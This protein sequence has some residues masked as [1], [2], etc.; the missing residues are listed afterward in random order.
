MSDYQPGDTITEL[1]RHPNAG[2]ADADFTKKL[3]KNNVASN[4]IV[5]VDEIETN[6]YSAS[7]TTDSSDQALW[8]IDIRETANPTDATHQ[9][10]WKVWNGEPVNVVQ[11]NAE[12]NTIPETLS[13][14][15]T[16]I[17]S[18]NE[19]VR[20]SRERLENI[21]NVIQSSFQSIGNKINS[22]RIPGRR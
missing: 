11:N 22:L 16:I 17:E 5:I 15:R 3:F 2:V 19:V 20:G 1:F 12:T 13:Y 21:T 9:K 7:F 6:I 8:E 10:E 4:V 14:L 18:T